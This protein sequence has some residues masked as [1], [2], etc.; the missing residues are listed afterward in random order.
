MVSSL[1]VLL[2]VWMHGGGRLAKAGIFQWLVE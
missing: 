1:I 2:A